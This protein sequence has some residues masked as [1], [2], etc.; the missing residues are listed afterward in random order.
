MPK[1]LTSGNYNISFVKGTLT[2]TKAP[3]TVTTKDATKVYGA[4]NP[5]FDVSYSGLVNGDTA[6][7]LGG[8]L[9]FDTTATASSPVGSYDV[10]PKGLTSNNY[11]ISFVKGTLKVV[12]G[13]K[14]FLQPIN[15]TAHQTGSTQSKFKLGQTI[16]VKFA[17]YDAAGNVVQQTVTP[18]FR[19][20]ERLGACDPVTPPEERVT[21]VHDSD[22]KYDWMGS[23]YQ[24]NW[25]T[26]SIT[27]AG[28]YRIYAD[29]TDGTNRWVDICLTK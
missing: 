11:N 5:T 13:W 17:I 25:S 9:A 22:G 29:L 26:K 15:D 10:T 23:H 4:A 3:L 12:Y 16:P 24:Y 27:S 7:S 14:G 20:S 8:T 18:N 28:E 1:G 6:A 19:K 2:V 21:V